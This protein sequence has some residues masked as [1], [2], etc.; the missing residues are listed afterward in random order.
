MKP[1]LLN[2]GAGA[3][4]ASSI[5]DTVAKAEKT[6]TGRYALSIVKGGV[7]AI[8]IIVAIGVFISV[9]MMGQMFGE[10]KKQMSVTRDISL[11][12]RLIDYYK[13]KYPEKPDQEIINLVNQIM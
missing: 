2:I 9:R 3:G 11:R 12:T 10:S 5:V 8:I 6:E 13:G 1:N 4:K 7:T